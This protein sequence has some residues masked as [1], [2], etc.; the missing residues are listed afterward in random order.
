MC[1][2]LQRFLDPE[3]LTSCSDGERLISAWR[4]GSRGELLEEL[5]RELPGKETGR[6]LEELDREL[7]GQKTGKLL[8]ELGR[9]FLARTR[10]K[11]VTG[12]AGRE[13]SGKETRGCEM[14]LGS[15]WEMGNSLCD[16]TNCH[17][18]TF[19]LS[20]SVVA[21]MYFLFMQHQINCLSTE[22]C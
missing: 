21:R 19:S 9:E 17:V 3:S 22:C 4:R 7:P 20:Y 12:T 10:E 2:S 1:S 15:P 13:L 11:E 6:L 16:T 8:E 18:S 14:S 5:G